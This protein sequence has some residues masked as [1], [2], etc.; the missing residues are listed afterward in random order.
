[1]VES[2]AVYSLPVMDEIR[3]GKHRMGILKLD[4]V[5]TWYSFG[6]EQ[7]GIFRVIGQILRGNWCVFGLKVRKEETFK[8]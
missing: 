3:K 1:M 4:L 5:L 7:V 6:I 8:K 2:K